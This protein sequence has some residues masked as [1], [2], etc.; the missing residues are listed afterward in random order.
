[1]EEEP[2]TASNSHMGF[3]GDLGQNTSLWMVFRPNSQT[4]ASRGHFIYRKH[5][6]ESR[7]DNA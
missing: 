2:E 4:G 1:M 3:A 5:K 6:I 7:G